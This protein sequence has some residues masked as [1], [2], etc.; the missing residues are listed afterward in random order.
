MNYYYFICVSTYFLILGTL[1]TVVT[2]HLPNSGCGVT[3]NSDSNSNESNMYYSVT[4]VV[5]Q[6]RHLRQITDQERTVRCYVDSNTFALRSQPMF[7]EVKRELLK[8][9]SNR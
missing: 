6:D 1:S 7:E 2:V 4:V 3:L 9:K 5:Q 8:R